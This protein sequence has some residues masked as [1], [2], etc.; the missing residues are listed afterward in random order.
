MELYAQEITT[1]LAKDR[2]SIEN[3]FVGDYDNE[4]NLLSINFT[5]LPAIGISVP[6][7]ELSDFGDAGNLKFDNA[8]YML[9]EE[10][11]FV[12]AYIEVTN[13]VNNK[14]YIYDNIGRTRLEAIE[15]DLNFVPL[16]IL[17]IASQE[18]S[19][20]VSVTENVLEENKQEKLITDNTQINVSTEVVADVDAEGK[21]ILN[22]L[23]NYKYEVIN[24]EFSEREDF[25]PGSYDITKS[26]A[27]LSLM[28]IIK[29]SFEDGDFAKYL[30]EGK[31]VKIVVTGTADGS[32]I[33]GKIAYNEQYGAFEAEPY[34]QNGE[35][36]NV[37]LTKA[38]GITEN[39]QLAFIRAV[40]VKNYL[41]SN[42]AT[43]Q[44]TQNSFAFHVEVAEE[45]GGEYRRVHIQFTI[46]DA[47]EQ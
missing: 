9:N 29:N 28:K 44:H 33:R 5:S 17:Q 30:K 20:L 4:S 45:T 38:T 22:Y 47:F 10:D 12:L 37:T 23:V 11:E 46:L 3:P 16:E 31:R 21:K 25:P 8:V 35:L 32:P 42:I 24:K 34:Y 1:D 41:V 26:N 39:T 40:S 6:S 2:I 7:S 43:L 15:T 36:N 13:E 18:E 19:N 27:A 14:V